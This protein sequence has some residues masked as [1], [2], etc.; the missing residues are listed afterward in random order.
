MTDKE[1]AQG[2]R[3][4]VAELNDFIVANCPDGISIHFS[5]YPITRSNPFGFHEDGLKVTMIRKL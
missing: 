5:K 4:K 3:E 2:L 1:F